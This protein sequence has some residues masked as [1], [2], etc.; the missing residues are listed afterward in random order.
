[1]GHIRGHP[2]LFRFSG[3]LCCSPTH[4]ECMTLSSEALITQAHTTSVEV[5]HVEAADSTSFEKLP[6]LIEL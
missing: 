2:C 5:C 4:N 3:V 6:C 1:M